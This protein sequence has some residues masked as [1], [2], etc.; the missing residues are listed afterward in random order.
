MCLYNEIQKNQTNRIGWICV[1][2]S[3][4]FQ[5]FAVSEH[6]LRFISDLFFEEYKDIHGINNKFRTCTLYNWLKCVIITF[7]RITAPAG[8][9]RYA[10][11]KLQFPEFRCFLNIIWDLYQVCLLKNIRIS[12]A[13]NFTRESCITVV[14]ELY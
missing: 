6:Y 10:Y 1:W 8:T 3:Y 4:N 5:Y 2:K 14:N 11:E 12:M 13:T 7:F 9:A